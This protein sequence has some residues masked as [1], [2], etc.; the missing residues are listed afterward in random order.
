MDQL[1]GRG[2]SI[3]NPGGQVRDLFQ[4]WVIGRRVVV[5]IELRQLEVAFRVRVVSQPSSGFSQT[6][7]GGAERRISLAGP[8]IEI[9]CGG[10]ILLAVS[11]PAQKVEC[12]GRFWIARQKRLQYGIA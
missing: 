8:S 7:P 6:I 12:G 9:L 10:E 4:Q 11:I 1:F 3:F 2:Q 5:L